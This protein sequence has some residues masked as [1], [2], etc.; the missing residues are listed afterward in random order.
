MKIIPRAFQKTLARISHA[1]FASLDVL[2]DFPPIST[3]ARTAYWTPVCSSVS[4]THSVS[5]SDAETH[6]GELF[7]GTSGN[8]D[9][10][11]DDITGGWH[12]Q[13]DLNMFCARTRH[14]RLI[15][16]IPILETSRKQFLW[17]KVKEKIFLNWRKF[18]CFKKIFI[19]VNKSIYMDQ[20]IFF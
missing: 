4:M 6:R 5:H 15:F 20:R 17:Y 19:N 7:N 13:W 12:Y 18:C 11:P 9:I 8:S 3:S 2:G 14:F 16:L 10:L 1:V